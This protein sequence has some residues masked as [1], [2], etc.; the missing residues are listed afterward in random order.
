MQGAK[1]LTPA[2]FNTDKF[3]VSFQVMPVKFT[4]WR[5]SKD[6]TNLESGY[7]IQPTLVCSE[8]NE[9]RVN[10]SRASNMSHAVQLNIVGRYGSKPE[11]VR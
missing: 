10:K 11:N 1:S 7:L 8:F 9:D 5:S 2:S 6:V 3:K 4:M